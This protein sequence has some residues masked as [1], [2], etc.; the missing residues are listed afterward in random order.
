DPPA[1]RLRHHV[2]GLDPEHPARPPIAP[3]GGRQEA[4][5]DAALDLGDPVLPAP[6]IV[7]HG[8]DAA[9]DALRIEIEPLG[10]ARHGELRRQDPRRFRRQGRPY[11]DLIDHLSPL[12]RGRPRSAPLFPKWARPRTA[13][14]SLSGALSGAP[15]IAR[16]AIGS[17]LDPRRLLSR[18]LPERTNADG[19]P[20]RS[21][22]LHPFQ[23]GRPARWPGLR[24]RAVP[25][26]RA[27][28]R[29]PR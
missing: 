24:R 3:L 15:S 10:L 8:G 18:N 11:R 12:E 29:G 9:P 1:A 27:R 7:E 26:D 6:R 4:A 23:R 28:L 25:R 20:P 19:T 22:C 17:S 21:R 13:R 14:L 16:A 5:G 2:D